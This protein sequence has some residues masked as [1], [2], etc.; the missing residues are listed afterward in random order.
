M[1]TLNKNL[2][3][4]SN[5]SSNWDVPLNSNF[6]IL[7]IAFGGVQAFNLAAFAGGT[8]AVSSGT[9]VGSYPTNTA[10]YLPL[11]FSI[12][13]TPTGN[14]TLQIPSTVGGAWIVQN[15]IPSAT[16]FTLTI[17][18]GG[19]GA[20]VVVPNG[21]TRTIYSD[22][23]N[24][25]F[26]DSQTASAGSNTQVIYNSGTALTGSANLIFN[27][28]TLTTN[29]LAVS[30]NAAISGAATVAGAVTSGGIIK[31]TSGGFTFPDN[32]TQT[33]A[34]VS[35]IIPTGMSSGLKIQAT[36]N[37]AVTITASQ[38]VLAITTSTYTPS[39]ISLTL[40]TGTSGVNGLDTGTIAA[41]TWYAVW[42][43]YNGTTVAGLLSLS[44]TAP[45]MPVGYT[46]KARIGWVRTDGSSNLLRTIQYGTRAQYI[47]SASGYPLM[48]S[49]STSSTWSAIST[50]NYVPST[51][52]AIV[53]AISKL[54]T[55]A[56]VAAHPNNA[57]PTAGSLATLYIGGNGNFDEPLVIQGTM[58]LESSSVYWLSGSSTGYF[59]AQGWVDNV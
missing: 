50:A 3:T 16:A 11:T 9:Y 20:T 41:S 22:G 54:T 44:S 46:Y 23:T 55:S 6:N 7:D 25:Y 38:I 31:S 40:G 52:S 35:S 39:T 2:T 1:T 27:G 45:T 8:I 37:T 29:A 49:G 14:T 47:T 28:T 34:L 36:S 42:V 32:T 56:P 24:I 12:T 58:L 59:Y 48:A 15:G 4:P 43:I 18:S 26:S 5:N 53:V 19:G 17:S 51:A 30:T 13:G 10:S 21:T 57:L 33:T